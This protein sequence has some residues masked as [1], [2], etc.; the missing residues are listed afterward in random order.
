[1]RIGGNCF[2]GR[3]SRYD[4]HVEID[5]VRVDVT[6]EAEIEPWRPHTGYLVFG[7][8]R[9]LEFSWL[10]AVPQGKVT[11][12]YDVS[13]SRTEVTGVGY[14]D[15]NWGNVG[16]TSI[17]HDWYWARGQAGPYSV[18]ASQITS[19]RRYGHR[20]IT[21]FMLARDGQVVADDASLVSFRA[22]DV[23]KDTATG[24]PVANLTEYVHDDGTDR[25]VVTF[26]KHHELV[27]GT[28]LEDARMAQVGRPTGPVRRR[29][30][31]LRRGPEGRTLAWQRARRGVQRRGDLGAHVL[32][33]RA[34]RRR[35]APSLVILIVSSREA[36][37]R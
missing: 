22:M 10:P 34:W 36:M 1:M 8:E 16:M 24:K 9:D 27:A 5:D 30:P 18:I 4:I 31:P 20:P 32:R 19:H 2:E 25:Y 28:F 33:S 12:S 29:V 6:L 14:H 26:T 23:D 11:G 37:S 13:G 21:I 7:A 15:H 3:L 35:R 17:I